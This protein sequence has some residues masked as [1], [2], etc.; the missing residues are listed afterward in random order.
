[1]RW[2][3][4]CEGSSR[5]VPMRLVV[6]PERLGTSGKVSNLVQ[7]GR[8][9]AHEFVIVNDADIAVGPRYLERVMRGFAD[10]GVGM[11]TALYVGRA[12]GGLWSRIEALGISTDFMPGVLTARMLEGGIG[13]GLG[14]TLAMRGVALE[15]AGGF[16]AVRGLP[17]G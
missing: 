9:A 16:E 10:V 7:M 6:C 2:W 14:S 15:A 3:S 1:M 12:A 11:V 13:F 5:H 17:G 4:G 8:V